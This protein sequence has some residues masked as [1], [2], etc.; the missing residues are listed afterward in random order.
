MIKKY[1]PELEIRNKALKE[2]VSRKDWFSCILKQIDH[3]GKI[4]SDSRIKGYVIDIHESMIRKCISNY[5]KDP[6]IQKS[7]LE[8]LAKTKKEGERI[9]I[10]NIERN[11]KNLESVLKKNNVQFET[12]EKLTNRTENEINTQIPE[13]IRE[14]YTEMVS[15]MRERYLK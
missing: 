2:E 1:N 3:S 12:K 14:I 10:K 4:Y 9:K 6:D 5:L 8:Y 15:W 7:A 11:L 13:D